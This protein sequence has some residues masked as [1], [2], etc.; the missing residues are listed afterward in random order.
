[1]VNDFLGQSQSKP[2]WFVCCCIVAVFRCVGIS[3][4][5]PLLSAQISVEWG[6]VEQALNVRTI[7]MNK[8]WAWGGGAVRAYIQTF[9]TQIA[10]KEDEPLR[11][12]PPWKLISAATSSSRSYD[13]ILFVYTECLTKLLTLMFFL[14]SRLPRG[15]KIRSWTF[16]KALSVK[17]SSHD[18]LVS[19]LLSKPNSNSNS[20]QLKLRLDT[21]LKKIKSAQI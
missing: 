19:T 11:K 15:L 5:T 6:G 17:S 21:V 10:F 3:K 16:S 8:V 13:V 4:S 9:Y 14:I 1:M 2:I 20:I 18:F 12:I 7:L